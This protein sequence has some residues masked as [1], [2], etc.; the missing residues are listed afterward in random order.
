MDAG[1]RA[2][3][4]GHDDA[5]SAMWAAPHHPAPCAA[6]LKQ[7]ELRARALE[8]PSLQHA[9][10]L[11]DMAWAMGQGLGP[12]LQPQEEAEVPERQWTSAARLTPRRDCPAAPA[13]LHY[14][15]VGA[16][17]LRLAP[18][19]TISMQWCSGFLALIP[20]NA[21]PDC[22]NNLTK[23][24]HDRAGALN[25]RRKR[26]QQ[27]RLSAGGG[28]CAARIAEQQT[29][30]DSTVLCGSNRTGGGTVLG[31]RAAAKRSRAARCTGLVAAGALMLQQT[32]RRE[33]MPE[34]GRHGGR[35][36]CTSRH[37]LARARTLC[38]RIRHSMA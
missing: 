4:L 36:P 1:T 11:R 18:W 19:A 30:Y 5:A 14:Y 13:W 12:G 35:P 10:S 6:G 27:A 33:N 32:C 24:G 34:S 15:T 22:G 21:V 2:C 20:T 7:E 29:R 37:R 3:E 31:T 8:M 23:A 16:A 17:G 38:S 9:F 28:T 26:I 25:A